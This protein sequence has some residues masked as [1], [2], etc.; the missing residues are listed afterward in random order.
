MSS[1][2]MAKLSNGE[3]G[4]SMPEP[5]YR[6][7]EVVKVSLKNGG[8]RPMK[9]IGVD[10]EVMDQYNGEM[11]VKCFAQDI[12]RFIKHGEEFAVLAHKSDFV[13]GQP[14]MVTTKA[15]AVRK[16]VIKETV[17]SD[18]VDFLIGI[19]VPRDVK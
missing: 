5:F 18:K 14:I 6:K 16:V 11:R 1:I 4:V 17:P 8:E 3:W 13:D 9:I 15:G 19:P 10:C 2:R 7:G 12:P